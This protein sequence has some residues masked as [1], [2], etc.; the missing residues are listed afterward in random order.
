MGFARSSIGVAT[1]ICLLAG[2]PTSA[3]ASWF[4]TLP[5]ANQAAVLWSADLETGNTR[6]WSEYGGTNDPTWSSGD[7]TWQLV[8]SP[9]AAHSGTYAISSTITTSL[10]DIERDHIPA[11]FNPTGWNKSRAATI[12]GIE[13]STLDRKIRRYEL[14]DVRSSDDS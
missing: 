5:P 10:A 7:S 9:L 2:S 4:S 13:R 3:G 8:N 12:L 6:Q 11:T 1:F 14:A